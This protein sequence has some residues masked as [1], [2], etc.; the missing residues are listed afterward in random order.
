MEF[1]G[2]G[3]FQKLNFWNESMKLKWNFWRGGWAHSRKPSVGG[4]WV[5]SGKAVSISSPVRILDFQGCVFFFAN[6]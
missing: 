1:Q 6:S 2:G 4:V 3:G 5:F